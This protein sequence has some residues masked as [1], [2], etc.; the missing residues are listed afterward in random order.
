VTAAVR[1]WSHNHCANCQHL[2][3]CFLRE[4]PKVMVPFLQLYQFAQWLCDRWHIA[5]KTAQCAN[6]LEAES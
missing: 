2:P 3:S 5:E 1:Q 6:E 4:L